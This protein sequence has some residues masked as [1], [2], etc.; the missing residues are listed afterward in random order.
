MIFRIKYRQGF[1]IFLAVLL[2]GLSA[3]AQKDAGIEAL[4][5]GMYPTA[6]RILSKQLADSV[7]N[8]ETY[9]YLGEAHRL[10][11]NKD[12]A[13]YFY[14]LGAAGENPN[15]LC[16]IGKAGLM[17]YHYSSVSDE[18]IKKARWVKEYYRNP[19]LYVA[20]AKIYADNKRFVAA[21]E[22][23][24]QAKDLDKRYVNI[25]LTEGDILLQQIKPGAAAGKYDT[26]ILYDTLCKPAFLKLAQ[27]YYTA[28][29]YELAL[30]NVTKILDID[31]HFSTAVK[32]FGDISY[33]QGKYSNTVSAYAEYLQSPEAVIKD[34]IRYAYALFF[35]KD[36]QKAL[37]QIN[38]LI[39]YFPNNQVL[40][41]LRAYSTFEVGDY[42][43]GLTLMQAFLNSVDP[44]SIVPSDFKYYARLL[45]KNDQDSLSIIN[46]QKAIVLSTSPQEF[47]KEMALVYEKMNKFS[48]AASFMEKYIKT[49]KAPSVTDYYYWGRSCYFAAVAI[50]SVT[51]ENDSAQANVRRT[52]Y[53]KA[54]SIFSEMVLLSPENFL[55]YL[56]RARVNAILDPESEAGLA[57]PFYEKV[58][59]L[60]DLVNENYKKERI[61]SYQYLG[62]YYFLADDFQN[63]KIF[64]N[65]ILA[66]DPVNNVAIKA[67]EGMK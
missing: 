20:L 2:L 1:P 22:M 50:D 43:E 60:L 55:G 42:A 23:L 36:Y 59:K 39:L 45:S 29:N 46:Y 65:K 31:P 35:N 40:N 28:K 17:M 64:W 6:R 49:A 52:L 44:S 12:S 25:Y 21:Y 57:K 7:I 18:L 32:L 8:P 48:A 56:W 54:D 62:Y 3:M 16:L 51:I 11:G 67:I 61:E 33:D 5:S 66:I 15:S 47:Y 24:E 63:S 30:K 9:Y 27:I 37:D 13:A 26:A 38:Q 4:Y 34:Q 41:R 53:N 58:V 19:E 10:L 14:E